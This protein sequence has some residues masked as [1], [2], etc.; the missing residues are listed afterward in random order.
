MPVMKL[1]IFANGVSPLEGISITSNLYS[2]GFGETLQGSTIFLS[3]THTLA[4]LHAYK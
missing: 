1:Y 4:G 2:L 3:L